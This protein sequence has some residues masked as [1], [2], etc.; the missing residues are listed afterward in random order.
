MSSLYTIQRIYSNN[1]NNILCWLKTND[2]KNSS[3][4]KNS[5]RVSVELLYIFVLST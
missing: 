4:E 2:F 3:Y 5:N 1:I